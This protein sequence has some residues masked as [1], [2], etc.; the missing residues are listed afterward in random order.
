M[1]LTTTLSAA[2]AAALINFWLMLRCGSV[3]TSARIIH[4]DGGNSLLIKRMRAH[5][6]FVE[7]TPFVLILIGAIELAGKGGLWLSIVAGVYLLAR[8]AHPL[9]MDRDTPNALRVGGIAITML[10]LIG[11]AVVAVLITLGKI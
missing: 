1:I 7:S 3:R 6:N 8:V 2:A 11:L 10:T 4:G 9:G 5:A